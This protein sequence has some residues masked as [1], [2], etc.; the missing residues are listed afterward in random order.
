VR[1]NIRS[2]RHIDAVIFDLGGVLL[3]WNPRHLYRKLFT[4]TG[5]MEWFL[6]EICTAKWHDAHDRGDVTADSCAELAI[7]FPEWSDLIWAWSARSEEM[8]AGS[9]APSVDLLHDLKISG[10][11]CY[12]LTNMEAETYPLR[13]RRFPFLSWFDGTVVS[14]NE[15]MA[16]PD[17][18]IFTLLLERFALKASTTLMIDDTLENLAVAEHVGLQT[19][20]FHSPQELKN[21]LESLSLLQS[22]P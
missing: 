19:L 13:L 11:R 6:R 18:E 9:I 4:D 14:G 22:H 2:D 20:H 12:A 1:S 3:D 21:R 5:Q 7:R 17:R 8:V 15:R 10:M 16:K